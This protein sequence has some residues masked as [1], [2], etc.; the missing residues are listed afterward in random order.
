VRERRLEGLL[1]PHQD[2]GSLGPVTAA[3]LGDVESQ[4]PNSH[5]NPP[6][7]RLLSSAAAAAAAARRPFLRHSAAGGFRGRRAFAVGAG[8]AGVGGVEDE[9]FPSH[10]SARRCPS[11]REKRAARRASGWVGIAPPSPALMSPP[12][13]T[14]SLQRFPGLLSHLEP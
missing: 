3:L 7:L 5:H 2:P 4:V 12:N 14:L 8:L 1:P 10:L 9:K 13:H 6:R 11:E